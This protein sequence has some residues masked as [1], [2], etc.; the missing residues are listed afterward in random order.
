MLG[1]LSGSHCCSR[2]SPLSGTDGCSNPELPVTH[3]VP[4]P[5][6]GQ[7]STHPHARREG[8]APERLISKSQERLSA[9]STSCQDGSK[10]T[11]RQKPK[12]DVPPLSL[13]SLPLDL[14]A[15]PARGWWPC[16]PDSHEG[17]TSELLGGGHQ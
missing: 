1:S 11:G 5:T 14:R 4:R 10:L 16:R 13:A 12:E 7:G 17:A 3:P 9:F 8:T 6:G 2:L 15:K